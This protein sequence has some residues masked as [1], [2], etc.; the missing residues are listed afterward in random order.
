M[1]MRTGKATKEAAVTGKNSFMQKFALF[2]IRSKNFFVKLLPKM[3]ITS[4][5]K[6]AGRKKQKRSQV[7]NLFIVNSADVKE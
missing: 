6:F 3:I 5:V 4:K 2:N 7:S 1:L